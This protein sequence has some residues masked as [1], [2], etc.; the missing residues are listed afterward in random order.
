MRLVWSVRRNS[1]FD[2]IDLM[3][4][5]EQA[6]Q[7]AGVVE[8]AV[9]MGT[10]PGRSMLADAGMWPA[11]A[12]DAGP[13]D[14]LISVRASTEAAASG[15]IKSVEALLDAGR[16]GTA[17]PSHADMMPRTT[18]AAARSGGAANVAVIAVPGAYAAIE[19]H[20]A[21]SAGLHVFLFSDGVALEDEIVLKRRARDH[22]LLVMGP[23]CGTA[24]INGIGL[25]FANRVRRGSVGVV[26]ASGTGIQELTSLVHRMGAGVSHAIGTGGRDLQAEVGGLTTLQAVAALGADAETG[27]LLIVSKPPSPAAADAVLRASVATGKPVVACLLGYRGATPSGVHAAST[28]DEGASTAVRL[29][30]GRV[31]ALDRPRAPAP[32]VPGAILGLFTGGTLCDEARRVVGDGPAHRFIDFGAEEFTRGRPH[33]IIDPGQRNAAIVA[34]GDDGSVSVLLLDVVLGDCAHPDPMG[35]LRPALAEAR[36]RRR[37]RD[38]AIIAHV[39]GTDLDPQGLERQEEELRKLGVVVCASNRIAAETARALAEGR[40]AV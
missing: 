23:E 39:V 11:E 21:L 9:V 31:G 32:A 3:R 14:L 33:P 5:A 17:G 2:S 15:A 37:G 26:G 30:A 1:Y 6:R 27:V 10:P 24:I 12:P 28:L 35:A 40:D 36:A 29:A 25:G 18:A 4:V 7:L 20:Q 38:L 22:G 8:V 16:G 34:A 19:A 13:S